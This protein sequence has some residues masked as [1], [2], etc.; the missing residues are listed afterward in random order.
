[1]NSL[2][3][4]KRRLLVW[5]FAMGACSSQ[6]FAQLDQEQVEADGTGIVVPEEVRGFAQQSV[7]A[8][9]N[10]VLKGNFTY[11]VEKMYPRWKA[12]Q[13]KRL[14]SEKALQEQFDKAAV[15]MQEAG[16]DITAFKALPPVAFYRVWPVVNEG[17]KQ[18]RSE[19]DLT[20]H[21]VAVVPT[22]MTLRFLIENQP[23]R[24]FERS[25]YQLAVCKEGTND[26]TFIDGAALDV[27]DL[28]SIFP[29]LPKNMVL[30]AKEDKEIK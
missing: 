3:D 30:P 2:Q 5:L 6:L 26:W 9:G 29:L 17:V 24:T 27:N 25:S 22:K 1:M 21:I 16:I 19:K 23:P 18:V 11:A 13:A 14:G 20:Y 10:E 8:L 12:R 15:Q 4:M 7:Q 28:R